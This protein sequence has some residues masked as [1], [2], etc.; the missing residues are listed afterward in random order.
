MRVEGYLFLFIFVFL[1]VCTAVYLIW[2]GDPSGGIWLALSS[3]FGLSVGTYC[4]SIA[5]R[6]PER[7]EDRPDAEIEEG[8]G[9]VGFFSPH[10]WWPIAVA[11]AA[12]VVG[13][14]AMFGLWLFITGAV[15]VVVTATGFVF[16]YYVGRRVGGTF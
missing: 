2:S 4:L 5:R 11:A 9:E 3:G 16:E 6:I 12:T 13:F 14:G 1:I 10:S 7:P 15:L 8:A